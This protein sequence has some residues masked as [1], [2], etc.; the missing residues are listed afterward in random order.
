MKKSFASVIKQARLR[1]NLTIMELSYKLKV[2]STYFHKIEMLNEIPKRELVIGLCK[3]MGLQEEQ[4]L[5][6]A[7][8][9]KLKAYEAQLRKKYKIQ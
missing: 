5:K 9:D 6:L 1:K 7:V 8:R 2:S 3:V 4:M